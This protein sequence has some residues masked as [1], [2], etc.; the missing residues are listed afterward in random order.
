MLRSVQ[1][2]I[3]N[4]RSPFL[5]L[6][7]KLSSKKLKLFLFHVVL[8]SPLDNFCIFK[9]KN[10]NINQLPIYATNINK[11]LHLFHCVKPTS[12]IVINGFNA[13]IVYLVTNYGFRQLEHSPA[14]LVA[15]EVPLSI[16]VAFFAQIVTA[17]PFFLE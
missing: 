14:V 6:S 15:I 10:N 9:T 3:L 4:N 2:P 1:M 13:I 8:A 17:Y 11:S 12:F 5:H 16:L 7:S